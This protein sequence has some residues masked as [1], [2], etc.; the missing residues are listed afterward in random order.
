MLAA[1]QAAKALVHAFLPPGKSVN[2]GIFVL[3]QVRNP[4]TA[5]GLIRG[6][7]LPLFLGSVA[8]LLVFT[9]VIWRFHR[10]GGR[11]LPVAL[12]LIIGGALSN[13]IDRIFLEGVVDY[14]DLRFWPVFNLA[15]VAIVVGAGLALLVAVREVWS[16]GRKSAE[17][18]E[19]D[20]P[21]KG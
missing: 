7:P 3:R 1:D 2:L 16:E 21:P 18:T 8:L 5:F 19:E 10:G 11:R 20:P 9:L 4:G 15:D 6:G 12:G 17:K 13:I 14:I